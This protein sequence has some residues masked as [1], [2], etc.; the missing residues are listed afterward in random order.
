M[1]VL[2]LPGGGRS[3]EVDVP[4]AV[5]EHDDRGPFLTVAALEDLAGVRVAL[6]R[7]ALASSTRLR[8]G[9]FVRLCECATGLL[10]GKGGFGAGLRAMGKSHNARNK[11][12]QDFSFC[13]DLQGRRL[14]HANAAVKLQKLKEGD[15]SV[16]GDEWVLDRPSWAEPDH[17]KRPKKDDSVHAKKRQ[18][19]KAAAEAAAAMAASAAASAPSA[20]QEFSHELHREREEKEKQ[21]R[22]AVLAGLSRKR[23]PEPSAA[24]VESGDDDAGDDGDDDDDDDSEV[25]PD[26]VKLQSG[27]ARVAKS[28]DV[29]LITGA[30]E[31]CT[32]VFSATVSAFQVKALTDGLVQV[33]LMDATRASGASDATQDGVGDF[34]GSW[35]MDG[36]RALVWTEGRSEP[37]K[38]GARAWAEDDVVTVRRRTAAEVEFKLNAVEVGSCAVPA[39]ARLLPAVSL[40]EGEA[41][42]LRLD[43]SVEAP[44]P[45]VLPA[46]DQPEAA[47]LSVAQLEALGGDELKSELKALGLK[48]GGSVQERARRL[49]VAK[50]LPREDWCVV[51]ARAVGLTR[52]L[53]C[54]GPASCFLELWGGDRASIHP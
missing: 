26:G 45:Q 10:G 35:A 46:G 6:A 49:H 44:A 18:A 25:L 23:A 14:G 43:A 28:G 53:P 13:R 12:Q 37:F 31:F 41:I 7:R 8:D 32:V 54:Q 2:L 36:A 16:R 17:R 19:A 3:V 22:D 52:W 1:R 20:L 48:F 11:T 27:K 33:G 51:C 29:F 24:L 38:A 34:A 40:E 21:T 15:K 47:T 9:D 30:S 4:C 39:E 50:T 5:R 42:A